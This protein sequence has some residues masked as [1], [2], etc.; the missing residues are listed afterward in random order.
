MFSP[1]IEVQQFIEVDKNMAD[2]DRMI[3]MRENTYMY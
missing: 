3:P 1:P 2:E